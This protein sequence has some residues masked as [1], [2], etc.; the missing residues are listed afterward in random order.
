MA[1]DCRDSKVSFTGAHSDEFL[2]VHW[3]MSYHRTLN[4]LKTDQWK[5]I[6]LWNIDYWPILLHFKHGNFTLLNTDL[7]RLL[8]YIDTI[9]Q[10]WLSFF[11]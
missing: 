5:I 7:C 3:K 2:L 9:D 11:Y 8:L 10:Q 4:Y 1:F 6:F